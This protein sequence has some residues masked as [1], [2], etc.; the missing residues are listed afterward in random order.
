MTC[1]RDVAST[2]ISVSGAGLFRPNRY[3]DF[4]PFDY[5]CVSSLSTFEHLVYLCENNTQPS[6]DLLPSLQ[7]SPP[8]T[9]GQRLR[10][11]KPEETSFRSKST[12]NLVPFPFDLQS[13]LPRSQQAK[14]LFST[15][16]IGDAN[17][18]SEDLL[19]PKGPNELLLSL[20]YD[21]LKENHSNEI[22][23]SAEDCSRFLQ[24]VSNRSQS[25]DSNA[26][27][28]KHFHD[29]GSNATS[30]D[31]SPYGAA[32]KRSTP[33]SHHS[34]PNQ[35]AKQTDRNP[36]PNRESPQNT[37]N[38]SKYFHSKY[39]S[40][41]TS[42]PG[43]ASTN[44][45][46]DN[47][48]GQENGEEDPSQEPSSGHSPMWKCYIKREGSDHL[49]M[50]FV[51][52]TFE[53]LLLL[54][55]AP[56]PEPVPD[57]L[58]LLGHD[59]A[60]PHVT[61]ESLFGTSVEA[62]IFIRELP[63]ILPCLAEKD[64][65]KNDKRN[66]TPEGIENPS[67]DET[68]DREN[69]NEEVQDWVNSSSRCMKPAFSGE[70][71]MPVYTYSCQLKHVTNSL[72]ERWTFK[73]PEDVVHDFTYKSN[74]CSGGNPS[75][76]ER[77]FGKE[78]GLLKQEDQQSRGGSSDRRSTD[79][80]SIAIEVFKEHCLMLADLYSKAFVTGVFQSLQQSY[81][82]DSRDVFAAINDICDRSYPL[83]T[84]M[85]THLLA[86]C[87]HM[88]NLVHR[89]R[90]LEKKAEE[91]SGGRRTSADSV[92]DFGGDV[93][94]SRGG[95]IFTRQVSVRFQ[96]ID[97]QKE[98]EAPKIPEV[99]QLPDQILELSPEEWSHLSPMDCHQAKDQ[100]QLLETVR[101]KFQEAFGL[102]LKQVPSLP[103]FYFYCPNI[104]QIDSASDIDDKELA[105]AYDGN[106]DL[107]GDTRE[108]E[109]KAK[110]EEENEPSL[111]DASMESNRE[112]SSLDSLEG[113]SSTDLEE[114]CDLLP[115]FVHFTCTIKQKSSAQQTSVRKVPL[116]LGDLAQ[117]IKEP[118]RSV[119]F[120][121][122]K[123]TFDINCLTLPSEPFHRFSFQSFLSNCSQ[124]ST[125][126]EDSGE[127]PGHMAN[128]T[129]KPIGNPISH[130]P[131]LQSSAIYGFK[132]EIE[133]L[134]Q[135]E[136]ISALRHMFPISADTLS[137]VAD[138]IHN[139][140]DYQ[141]K[142]ARYQIVNM[143]F[144]FDTDQ[145]LNMFIQEFERMSLPGYKLTREGDYYFLIINKTQ[146]LNYP[147]ECNQSEGRENQK[148]TE[149]SYLQ[150]YNQQFDAES[151]MGKEE[152]SSSLPCIFP[153][154]DPDKQGMVP[155]VGCPPC[156]PSGQSQ[157][158]R[159]SSDGKFLSRPLSA[160]LSE[161]EHRTARSS[162]GDGRSKPH[163]IGKL[164]S[165][166]SVDQ[167]LKKSS[168]FT[169][170]QRP[171]VRSPV[172]NG[173][174]SR[175]C[176][177]PSGHAGGNLGGHSRQSTLPQS[178]SVIS[179]RNSTNDDG[180]D[181]D[182]SDNE[183]DESGSVSDISTIYPELPDFWLLMQ[184]HRDRT[185]VFF[186]SR[187][188]T[189][190]GLEVNGQHH[191]L[192][193]LATD[194]IHKVCRKV[195]QALLLKELNKTK[196]CLS[197]LV[198][199]ADQDFAWPRKKNDSD[200]SEEDEWENDMQGNLVAFM[201][202]MPAGFFACPVVWQHKFFLHPR[203]HI[204]KVG[205]E[206]AGLLVIRNALR[207][208]DVQNRNNMFV[209]EDLSSGNVFYLR[210]KRTQVFQEQVELDL[211]ASLSDSNQFTKQ[212]SQTSKGESDTVSLSSSIG[213]QSGRTEEVVELTVHG[214]ADVGTD[215]KEDLMQLLQKKLDDALLDAICVMLS[216]NPLCKLKRDDVSFI[217]KPQ[218]EPMQSL[219]LTIPGHFSSYLM[220][221]MYYLQ[222]NLLQFLH[223]PN[224][225]DS[226][227][228]FH[229]QDY[230]CGVQSAIP[231]D[232]VYLYVRPQEGGG[233]GIACIS[234]SLV[235]GR[236]EEVKLLGCPLP[237]KNTNCSMRS[238][239]EFEKFVETT[240]HE[241]STSDFRPGPTALVQFRIWGCGQL[242]FKNLCGRLEAS[243]R[244]TLCD[245]VM[246]YFML[247][248]PVCS[249]PRNL[250][251]T[252]GAPMS[253]LPASPTKMPSDSHEKRPSTLVR[254]LSAEP[255]NRSAHG[256]SSIFS[257]F[258]DMR[259]VSSAA[260]TSEATGAAGKFLDFNTA[261]GHQS[262]ALS[263]P[264][265]P[266]SAH[267]TGT[268]SGTG[269]R[270]SRQSR[271]GETHSTPSPDARS[272]Q[273]IIA[274]YE[275]GDK[276]SLHPDLSSLMEPWMSY[277]HKT[278]VP[279]VV[280]TTLNFQSKFSIDFVMKEL[281]SSITSICSEVTLKTFKMIPSMVPGQ[282]PQ[283]VPFIPC[284]SSIADVHLS[285]RLAGLTAGGGKIG[286]LGIGRN[287]YQ[288]QCTVQEH[289]EA[290]PCFPSSVLRAC[291]G[292]QK[293]MPQVPEMEG[294]VQEAKKHGTSEKI[295]I[296]RQKFLL[297][298]C[299]DKQMTLM[300]Y[301]WS[302]DLVISVEKTAT[303]LVQWHNA[304]SHVLD[305]II[306]QKMG[307]YHHFTFSDL[308]FTPTQNPFTQSSSEVDYLIKYHTP[309]RDYQRRS[310]SLSVK[311]RERN[312]QYPMKRIVPFDQTYKNLPQ[313]KPLDRLMCNICHD[314]VS[315]HGHQTQD[316]RLLSKQD[317]QQQSSL[318]QQHHQQTRKDATDEKI[319]VTKIM[320]PAFQQGMHLNEVKRLISQEEER[321]KLYHL[322]IG[323]FRTNW[324]SDANQP[325]LEDYL[326]QLKRAGRLFHYCATP[327]IFS[328]SWRQAVVQKTTG[329]I[330][331]TAGGERP[332]ADFKNSNPLLSSNHVAGHGNLASGGGA[333]PSASNVTTPATPDRTQKM[334]SRHSSGASNIS[335]KARQ[336]ELSG[337]GG[338]KGSGQLDPLSGAG[339]G[340]GSKSWETNGEDQGEEPEEAWHLELRQCFMD[341]Y[342]QYLIS[343]LGF[344]KVNV[345]PSGP[346]RGHSPYTASASKV[347]PV[348]LQ[349]LLT[350]GIIVMELSFRQEF[351]C[352]KMFA[353]DWSQLQVIVNQQMHL[354]FV[355]ECDK[356]KDLI[357]V[358]SF[359]HDFHLRCVQQ[360]LRNPDASSIFPSG[361][362][363]DSFLSDFRQIFPYPPSFS[364]NCLQQDCVTLPE[365]PFPGHMLYDYMLRQM[366]VQE[367]NVVR[368]VC[369]RHRNTKET[370]DKFALV[371]HSSFHLP[372]RAKDHRDFH[373]SRS[374]RDSEANLDSGSLES[375]DAGLVII[376]NSGRAEG[377]GAVEDSM[378]LVLKYFTVL[379]RQRDCYP[380]RTLHRALGE[381]GG[382]RPLG[383]AAS[384][385][386]SG[387]AMGD[388]CK[389]V[390]VK[391]H[392]GLRKEHVNYRGYSNIHQR[393]MYT[394][395]ITQSEKGKEK[396]LEMVKISEKKCRRDYLWQRL[397]I[398]R[399]D[400]EEG[401]KRRS[402]T[403]DSSESM[404]TP[405]S[406]LEFCELLESVAVSP[407][408][409]IDPQLT[410]LFNMP[411][412][413]HQGLF[414]V[415][416]TKYPEA[417]R[418]FQSPDRMTQYILVWNSNNLDMFAM[419]S[420]NK[421]EAKTELSAVMKEPVAADSMHSPS[422][423]NLP[424]YSL[425][426]HV[427]DFV[428]VCCYHVW[429]SML[430]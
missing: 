197:L 308:Q 290:T 13:L 57:N 218:S 194:N 30:L 28:A 120:G 372:A 209:V 225:V 331:K 91:A 359:A 245:I 59:G 18:V 109:E 351:F 275:A 83:E 7:P 14:L 332:P 233:K 409:E 244:H 294:K 2:V 130:L 199:E 223:T 268:G 177:A 123:V 273:S 381:F 170:L 239:D 321:N 127:E 217:Q 266:M 27:L 202:A 289:Q 333:G 388:P 393:L 349:K 176:S 221:L 103:D 43:S 370:G 100:K 396:I 302:S 8:S 399:N 339:K 270:L 121:D 226:N 310:S 392:I 5:E 282:L 255:G 357:H 72:I 140:V 307:L 196:S 167:S 102:C 285:R 386:S 368:M 137:F 347:G 214:I 190:N 48:S 15:F 304:R 412:S 259:Q 135:E 73:L 47:D 298:L 254:K 114:G 44:G 172:T 95:A 74:V 87:C 385:G 79:S 94:S 314:P 29:T 111:R 33:D 16:V 250:C 99:L 364:R 12:V 247:T 53:D 300:M 36:K 68:R 426:T 81:Y 216:R 146:P 3:V 124:S 229:F 183:Q 311:E 23:L 265:T 186:H 256:M 10:E 378:K 236:G 423:P 201:G 192:Y 420:L 377:S 283:G 408:N 61:A 78:S 139:G 363:L 34:S 133:S 134:M 274:M 352:V 97:L 251:D 184:I 249:V 131:K 320:D 125:E 299:T 208:F 252:Y 414:S 149:L 138:Y 405:L 379:T 361:F 42:K 410:P 96:E 191:S 284:K 9:P 71:Q 261:P 213:R 104:G 429:S 110:V 257:S 375:Y 400:T 75:L 215:I 286:L 362:D 85:T 210:L 424:L 156:A 35:T 11:K 329:R 224:Y 32:G 404:L 356:Y 145:S 200:G 335:A 206:P 198:P 154:T 80:T 293:H 397:I 278:G 185:E 365:L 415:L 382:K 162:G 166:L 287:M 427:E 337:L 262:D 187:E 271:P 295:F 19:D 165:E 301:N 116:C 51:P 98:D 269:N 306:A 128:S 374:P 319:P 90:R 153:S 243:V 148:E 341:E 89:A 340:R 428:N 150:Q 63:P 422:Q 69:K 312:Y 31:K 413:W 136:V 174:R 65:V 234:V 401:N 297:I 147:E 326:V 168:S 82:L 334:R 92:N 76:R 316:L 84:D 211:E 182:I 366:G 203:L 324:K 315:R 21:K 38:V 343:E 421:T 37:E 122:F 272:L 105:A 309:P 93:D 77:C 193:C 305:S 242:D 390:A 403:S 296:P 164:L 232:K 346:K 260:L 144:V 360:Y 417:Y 106:R 41:Q 117:S 24:Q 394:A 407:L 20:F 367:M 235:D 25:K 387:L 240:R 406:S 318:A 336:E 169:G 86:S 345:D 353:V 389:P 327:L 291:R 88:Q 344:I 179:S 160:G 237:V 231:S 395:L 158:P 281:Q 54:N 6:P 67:D 383:Q 264:R 108:E 22:L 219:L 129:P 49:L 322:Y 119:D 222:Q 276:G 1:Q 288:W 157:R 155:I 195:N 45:S 126:I 416:M 419:L 46:L 230:H 163:E 317:K 152:R 263:L 303:R 159:S 411:I 64:K 391:Q 342:Q 39:T 113:N 280:K 142:T 4:Y 175:H 66:Q 171:Q 180:F 26:G 246:E 143:Q 115:L 292:S 178:P 323:W 60:E 227:P 277:C 107:I 40:Q 425:Q 402:E 112:V 212:F 151:I 354:I 348:N 248:V 204:S 279:S 373:S 58:D 50:T 328:A 56:D 325:I 55:P 369:H 350:G 132:E 228:A 430:H 376:N 141:I 384:V 258:V 358:H 161:T 181:G 338:R 173:A 380:I 267:S 205:G 118:L 371:K 418:C 330:N 238:Q 101:A 398:S 188:L 52:S 70:L 17:T 189:D 220:A 207:T 253:S 241:R 313:A 355:D 62:E